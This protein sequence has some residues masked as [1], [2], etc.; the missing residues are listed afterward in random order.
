M[1]AFFA[2]VQID[3]HDQNCQ[4]VI[5]DDIKNQ[6]SINCQL[7]GSHWVNTEDKLLEIKQKQFKNFCIRFCTSH[8]PVISY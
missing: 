3:V 4:E 1:I 7:I 8:D 5:S 6:I 2:H